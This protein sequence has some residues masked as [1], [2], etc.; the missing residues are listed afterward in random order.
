MHPSVHRFA[1]LHHR[2]GPGFCRTDVDHFDWLW[3]VDADSLWTW[4]TAIVDFATASK[5]DFAVDALA[6][7]DHR[8][9]YLDYEG[10]LSDDRG[11]V[12][13][14]AGGTFQCASAHQYAHSNARLHAG[15]NADEYPLT[16]C[17]V[18][19]ILE[20]EN[21]AFSPGDVISF[22]RIFVDPSRSDAYRLSVTR[23]V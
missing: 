13:R 16:D 6:M 2:V 20:C 22:G 23:V 15:E 9:R 21:D 14:V 8:L 1:V 5:T 3:Q 10:D 11:R 12:N 18:A 7:P 17:F 4:S 19:K